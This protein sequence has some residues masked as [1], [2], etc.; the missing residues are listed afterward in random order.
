MHGAAR[1][2]GARRRDPR[3]QPE[4]R[5]PPR[6]R[7]A[8]RAARRPR[9]RAAALSFGHLQRAAAAARRPAVRPLDVFHA[10]EPAAGTGGAPAVADFFALWPDRRPARA[11]RPGDRD[12]PGRA[13]RPLAHRLAARRKNARGTAL[14]GRRRVPVLAGHGG[15]RRRRDRR[16]HPAEPPRRARPHP[17]AGTGGRAAVRPAHRRRPGPRQPRQRRPLRRLDGQAARPQ[18]C[19]LLVDAGQHRRVP[20]GGRQPSMRRKPTGT[21]GKALVELCENIADELP[22]R[23]GLR[24]ETRQGPAAPAPHLAILGGTGFIGAALV[25]QAC[26]ANLAVSVM[27]RS[28]NNLPAVF[29]RPTRHPA[30]GRHPRRRRRAGRHRRLRHSHQ[31]R[32]RRRRQNVRRNPRRHARR[33]RNRGKSLPR[34]RHATPDPCRLDRR[35]LSRPAGKTGH[36]RHPARSTGTSTRRLRPRQSRDRPHAAAHAHGKKTAGGHPPP[37]RRRRRAAP[38]RSTR[39]SASSTPSSTASAG[40]PAR[41]P[42]PSCWSTTSPPPS[43]PPSPHPASTGAATTSSAT[44]ARPPAPILSTS[45][46]RCNGRCASIRSRRPG[47]GWRISANGWSSAPPAAPCRCRPAA[48][49]CRAAWRRRSTAPTPSAT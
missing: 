11:G 37:R 12:R 47:C 1:R 7:P 15:L 29:A 25:K 43:S 36:R 6:L 46:A 17:L 21:F 38:R 19:F 22:K 40:M 18:R 2:R 30:Q 45:A 24:P 35:A 26:D 31:S 8:A 48:I 49:S 4:F 28:T 41:I 5:A 32:P 3:R 9:L 16:R 39:A 20:R 13:V 10:A 44:S 34:R 23:S 33:R 42:C 27:A 14:R